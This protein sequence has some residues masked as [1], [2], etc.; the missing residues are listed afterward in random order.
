M[1]YLS[2]IK[3]TNQ[4]PEIKVQYVECE[5]EVTEN[6]GLQ[7]YDKYKI[8]VLLSDGLNGVLNDEVIVANAGDVLFFRPDEMH[9][10]QVSRA[11]THRYFDILIPT[12]YFKSFAVSA[13]KIVGFLEHREHFKGNCIRPNH[14]DRV[15]ILRLVE[16]LAVRL[17][18]NETVQTL[19]S[20]LSV[21]ELIDL[22]AGMYYE[23]Y[24]AATSQDVPSCVKSALKFISLHY[25]GKISLEQ[26][27]SQ[28]CCSVTYLSKKFKEY[29]GCS[30]YTYLTQ[31]RIAMAQR[32]LKEDKSV[33]Q[34]C[35]ECG[36]YDCSHFIKTFKKMRG[37]TP[38]EYKN[39]FAPQRF[40][41][42]YSY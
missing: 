1:K 24:A 17:Q 15:K 28:T 14:I 32:L 19:Q 3:L 29:I 25:D 16:D 10:A 22:C 38:L 42:S 4:L 7:I 39:Q 23:G 40:E 21:F 8:S 5:F 26:V 11:G 30:V 33:T 6:T 20:A 18:T 13:E 34:V 41:K 12:D 9:F 31:Y 27:A 2:K 37:V 36:F 35:Y